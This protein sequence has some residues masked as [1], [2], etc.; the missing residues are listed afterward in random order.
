[1]PKKLTLNNIK[2]IARQQIEECLFRI[3]INSSS[4]LKW[5]YTKGHKWTISFSNIKYQRS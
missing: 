5:Y 2:E 3:Y 4:Y 1:M